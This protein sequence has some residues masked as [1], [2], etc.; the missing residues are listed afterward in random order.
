MKNFNTYKNVQDLVAKYLDKKITFNDLRE[1]I[2]LQW[3]I[4][5][6]KE[7]NGKS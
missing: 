5:N 6:E 1:G 3:L 2:K 4:D 7:R